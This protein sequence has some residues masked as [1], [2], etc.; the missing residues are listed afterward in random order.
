[1]AE[2]ELTMKT[3]LKPQNEKRVKVLEAVLGSRGVRQSIH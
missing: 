3:L 1:M 2:I